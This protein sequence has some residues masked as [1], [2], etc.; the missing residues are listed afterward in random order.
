MRIEIKKAS[1][2]HEVKPSSLFVRLSELIQLLEAMLVDE[3]L[4]MAVR[5]MA[6]FA[7]MVE[8]HHVPVFCVVRLP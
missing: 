2:R 7:C 4:E 3:L 8:N 6:D 1:L 5:V